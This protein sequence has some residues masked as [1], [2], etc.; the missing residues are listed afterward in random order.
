MGGLGAPRPAGPRA[1]P[2]D[3]GGW[4]DHVALPRP[5]LE[6]EPLTD[7]APLDAAEAGMRVRVKV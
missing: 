7:G 6:L 5:P 2:D 4:A 3:D 1:E